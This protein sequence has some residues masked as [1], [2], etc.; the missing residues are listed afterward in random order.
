MDTKQVKEQYEVVCERLT[1]AFSILNEMEAIQKRI[2]FLKQY[3]GFMRPKDVCEFLGITNRK[4]NQ[5]R[6]C[7]EIAYYRLPSGTVRYLNVD[8]WELKNKSV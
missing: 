5:M 2:E 4:L 8:I 1:E 6:I 3:P 7:G